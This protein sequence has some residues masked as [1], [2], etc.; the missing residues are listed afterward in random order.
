ME[1]RE[2]QITHEE[3]DLALSEVREQQIIREAL[4]LAQRPSA[5]IALAA[6][7]SREHP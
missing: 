5:I 7:S 4:D 2:L 1:A 6:G 3:L